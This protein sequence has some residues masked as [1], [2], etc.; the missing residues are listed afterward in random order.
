[1][2][3]AKGASTG[4]AAPTPAVFGDYEMG[5]SKHEKD[6]RTA[7][8]LDQMK[9]GVL[10][11]FGLPPGQQEATWRIA[12]NAGDPGA[13]TPPHALATRPQPSHAL[14]VLP[15]RILSH[16]LFGTLSCLA[17]VR[18]H[19]ADNPWTFYTDS[20][21]RI[22]KGFTQNPKAFNSTQS[23]D[24]IYRIYGADCPGPEYYAFGMM[25]SKGVMDAQKYVY[26]ATPAATVTVFTSK[27]LQ[28][29]D[30]KSEVPGPD[31]YH[32][33]FMSNK[34]TVRDAGAH[35]RSKSSR[36]GVGKYAGTDGKTRERGDIGT[37][38]MGPHGPQRINTPDG[39]GPGRYKGA[40]YER[41]LQEDC[42]EYIRR[43]SRLYAQKKMGFGSTSAQRKQQLYGVGNP[44]PVRQSSRRS[45]CNP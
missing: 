10:G 38:P 4:G 9:Q 37:G 22:K 16:A 7:V 45:S 36:W 35:M 11:F 8:F 6:V 13:C 28:R 14:L 39:V 17:C 26:P 15:S 30:A 23:K 2:E 41:T 1:M 18:S 40:E 19:C 32:P 3:N 33:N 34:A 27:S 44:D 31:A 21:E 5:R 25:G 43:S 24:L 42:D 20:G 12:A 29:P